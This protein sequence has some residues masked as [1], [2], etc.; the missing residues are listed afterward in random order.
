MRRA[1]AQVRKGIAA[2]QMPYG[3]AIVRNGRVIAC[4]HNKVIA[5]NDPTAHAEVSAIR[6]A[7]S[8]LGRRD[9]SDCQ[10]YA[11]CE[12]CAMC[13]GACYAAG[14]SA[15]YFGASI[16]DKF[17]FGLS[18]LGI[19]ASALSRL[20]KK[21]P[22]VVAGLLQDECVELFRVYLQAA[23]NGRNKP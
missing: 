12:P 10:V 1:I 22:K 5:E 7:C 13:T 3:A 8:R 16:A 20:S 4:E 6:A 17:S 21:V 23:E 19:G 2:G 18:D 11:T 15:I 9:L 14:V